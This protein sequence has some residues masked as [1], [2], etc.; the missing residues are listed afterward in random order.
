MCVHES[1]SRVWSWTQQTHYLSADKHHQLQLLGGLCCHVA[2]GAEAECCRRD[3]L[4]GMVLLAVKQLAILNKTGMSLLVSH[5]SAPMR[6]PVV[7]SAYF[8]PS[9][10]PPREHGGFSQRP[11]AQT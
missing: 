7:S 3:M 11:L 6:P 8:V 2:V 10:F 5:V 1:H 4:L 9:I